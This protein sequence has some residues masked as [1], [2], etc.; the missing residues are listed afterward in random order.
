MADAFVKVYKKLLDWEWYDNINTKVLFL[1][2]LLKANWKPA[3]WHGIEI[4]PG[5]FITSLPTLSNETHLSI[6][7]VRTA[8]KHLKSTG[9]LTDYQQSN[10]RVITVNNWEE[11]QGDNRR[12][13][14]S[15]T[16]H[17]QTANSL[18][19]ADKEYKEYKEK[20]EGKE[21][22][23]IYGEYKHVR[24]TKKELDR[25]NNDFGETETLKAIQFLDEYIQMKGYKA[26]DHNL[27]LRKWVYK[28]V[29]EQEA[30]ENKSSNVF[31]AWANA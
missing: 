5:Q 17:Q 10:F 12:S 27:A 18:L 30:R 11:Y 25:L 24:L 21:V 15:L 3:K 9:E 4:Q 14:R 31:D 26:K 28:A 29:K 7:E 6:Q 19:T 1:H 13:N 22:K 23:N 16:D 2:C 20:E 8:L